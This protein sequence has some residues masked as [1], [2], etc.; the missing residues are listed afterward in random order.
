MCCCDI[1]T[2]FNKF[3]FIIYL[4]LSAKYAIWFEE[5][6]GKWVL[7]DVGNIGGTIGNIKGPIVEE[8]PTN[9]ASKWQFY[10]DGKW[11]KAGN[12][13]IFE[14]CTPSVVAKVP[15]QTPV[16]SRKMFNLFKSKK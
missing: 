6:S 3:P 1:L 11:Y 15:K 4:L 10:E 8:W 7:G 9:I 14:D 16:S 2:C 12:D 5:K 13:I